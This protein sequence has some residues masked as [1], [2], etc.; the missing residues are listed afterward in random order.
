[1]Q[2]SGGWDKE[3]PKCLFCSKEDRFRT[4]TVH[5]HMTTQIT[6]SGKHKRGAAVCRFESKKDD[7]P[8][9]ARFLARKE[10]YNRY[11]EKQE[12]EQQAASTVLKRSM[13]DRE[14]ESEFVV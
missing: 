4:F 13:S 3:H 14:S 5:C 10:I 6:G 11:T 2:H 7:S 9:K 12:T 8:L 1:M